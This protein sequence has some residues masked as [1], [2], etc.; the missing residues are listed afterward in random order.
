MRADMGLDEVMALPTTTSQAAPGRR[1]RPTS[2]AAPWP[3]STPGRAR[4]G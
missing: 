1:W 3:W 2:S 4:R